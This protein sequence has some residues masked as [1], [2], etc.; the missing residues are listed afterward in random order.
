MAR[1]EAT[2]FIIEVLEGPLAGQVLRLSGRGLPLRD[3][4]FSLGR[5]QRTKLS[6][7]SGNKQGSHQIIGPVLLPSTIVGIWDERYLGEDVPI[8]MV[9]QFE[10]VHD[11]GAQVRMFWST[12]ERTGVI[13]RFVWRPGAKTG[14]LHT[15]S[16]ECS[17]EWNSAG[18]DTPARFVGESPLTLREQTAEA[19][20]G[21]AD[22]AEAIGQFID[23]TNYYVG[24]ARIP[25]QD[26]RQALED[27][28]EAIGPQLD[29]LSVSASRMGNE[30]DIRAGLLEDSSGAA[31][32]AQ[33]EAGEVAEITSG[34]F[35]AAATNQDGL[36]A[37][38]NEAL[39]RYELSEEALTVARQQ[40]ELRRRLEA[41]VRPPIFARIVAV[42]GS[43][44]RRLAN[45]WYGQADLW[46]RIA[47]QNGLDGSVI[48]DDVREI[49]IPLSLPDATDQKRGC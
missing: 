16:W 49:L 11:S 47:K 9:E 27:R 44:L 3:G 17:F 7:Y 34:I 32:R 12:I 15:I 24:L 42:P 14:G 45:D 5:K 22:L 21:L 4:S 20:N 41:L 28:V 38:L 2:D 35:P 23:T 10:A 19:A 46:D 39:V 36:V 48:P 37:I 33:Q 40:Y 43:D 26:D 25:F 31:G 29:T 6:F 1:S 30:P 8:Q 13:E 18:D